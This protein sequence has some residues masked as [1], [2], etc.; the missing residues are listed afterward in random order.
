MKIFLDSVGCRLNQSEIESYARQFRAAGHQL[1]PALNQADILVLNTCAVTAAASSDSRQKVR[2]AHRAGIS[3]VV[4]TGCWSD[5][6]PESAR[7]M[8]GVSRVIPNEQ[9]DSLV[10]E[11]LQIQIE[12][13]DLD[14]VARSPVPGSRLRTRAYIKAQDGCD[15]RCTFCVTTI[16]RGQGRS[17]SLDEIL[18]DV[19]AALLGGAKEVVLTGVHLGSWGKDFEQAQY[20][21]ELV[22][23]V[24]AVEELPRLRLSSL[25]PWNLDE[26]F[27]ALWED[28]RLCRHL[29]LPL[30]SGSASTLRRM[31]RNTTPEKFSALVNAARSTIPELAITSDVIVGFPG[32]SDA[33]FEESLDFIEAMQFSDAHVFTYSEREGTAAARMPNAVHHS[34]RKERSAQVRALVAESGRDYRR[35]FLGHEMDVLWESEKVLNNQSWHLSGLTDN[36]LR[37]EASSESSRWNQFSRA[38]LT[39]LTKNGLRASLLAEQE[40]IWFSN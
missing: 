32:E 5:L 25:E 13:F 40:P 20:I 36:Y 34:T 24:L 12:D 23:A 7:Q 29:H 4:V 17:K 19:R 6:E 26:D 10:S 33:E 39:A 9:K 14:S 2:Q 8:P 30:Q 16:A 3:E 21:K 1:V 18:A 35:Q 28:P 27:F 31:A 22:E 11:L 37:V 38:R 15:Q